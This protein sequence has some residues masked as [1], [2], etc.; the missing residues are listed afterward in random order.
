MRA[1]RLPNEKPLPTRAEASLAKPNASVAARAKIKVLWRN[2]PLEFIRV[3]ATQCPT[4]AR[5]MTR[6]PA[7]WRWAAHSF[8]RP[9]RPC[10]PSLRQVELA[11]RDVDQHL[12]HGPFAKPVFRRRSFPTDLLAVKAL[13]PDG[14]GGGGRP[15]RNTQNALRSR[16]TLETCRER[17]TSCAASSV[18]DA[19]KGRSRRELSRSRARHRRRRLCGCRCK[20]P[21]GPP[22]LACSSISSAS[23][24]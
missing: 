14:E 18:G 3:L 4:R 11:R 5:V 8:L 13:R 23:R 7:P 24:G 21:S 16:W 15:R 22:A 6:L 12:V 10:P 17:S 1:P 9:H 2:L 20:K 19:S